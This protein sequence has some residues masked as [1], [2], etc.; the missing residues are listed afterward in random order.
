MEEQW[1]SHQV[2]LQIILYLM[3]TLIII[4]T[5]VL[6]TQMFLFGDDARCFNVGCRVL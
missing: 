3:L 1:K 6:I 2:I 5:S 4:F